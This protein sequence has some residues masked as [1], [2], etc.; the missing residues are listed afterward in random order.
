MSVL[1]PNSKVIYASLIKN[2]LLND[3]YYES[4]GVTQ[5][6]AEFAAKQLAEKE[7]NKFTIMMRAV[8]IVHSL[9]KGEVLVSGK[10]LCKADL[11][12]DRWN[13]LTPAIERALTSCAT[14]SKAR[15]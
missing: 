9:Q 2:D 8:L 15:L 1:M 14:N 12:D 11:S 6:V 4:R 5:A 13:R 7:M 3:Q 10:K